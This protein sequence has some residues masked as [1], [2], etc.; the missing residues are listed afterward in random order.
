MYEGAGEQLG[1]QLGEH[2]FT[3][4]ECWLTDNN[5]HLQTKEDIANNKEFIDLRKLICMRKFE[6]L[7]FQN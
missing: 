3:T 2:Y 5:I 6:S 1:E 4:N 7:T